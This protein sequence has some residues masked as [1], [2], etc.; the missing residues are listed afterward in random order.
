[1]AEAMKAL[2]AGGDFEFRGKRYYLHPF[3][4]DSVAMFEAWLE[5]QAWDS[6]ERWRHK[7]SEEVYQRR[8]DA[9]ARLVASQR[10]RYGGQVAADAAASVAG[11]RQI[12]YLMLARD[13][14][15]EDVTEALVGEMWGEA[16][17]KLRALVRAANEDPL[18]TP[19]TTGSAGP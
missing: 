18:G 16:E 7:V 5:G 9:V 12:L 4:L 3:D 13:S 2:G 1:M 19:P 6:A 17:A 11:M 10:F 14:R 8:L 15:N